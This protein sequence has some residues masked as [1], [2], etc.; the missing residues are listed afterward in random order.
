MS[1]M[2]AELNLNC[3]VFKDWDEGPEN[4]VFTI[5]IATGNNVSALKD[6]IKQEAL[7]EVIAHQLII[8][9]PKNRI[10]AD[11]GLKEELGGN[12]FA[13]GRFEKLLP[14]RLLD[15]IFGGPL[16]RGELNILVQVPSKCQWF[17]VPMLF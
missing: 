1:L 15:S 3:L 8:W 6:R 7:P 11:V 17:V 13:D 14:L 10:V 9:K 4:Y 2:I 5:H 16:D 12:P